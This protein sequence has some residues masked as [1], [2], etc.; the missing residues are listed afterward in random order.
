MCSIQYA[1]SCGAGLYN[2][3]CFVFGQVRAT[4]DLPQKCGEN[5]ETSVGTSSRLIFTPPPIVLNFSPN[6]ENIA[7]KKVQTKIRTWGHA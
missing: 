1:L 2:C 4:D 5:R 6:S 3:A 7:G